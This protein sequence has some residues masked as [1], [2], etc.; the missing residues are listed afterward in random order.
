MVSKQHMRVAVTDAVDLIDLNSAN[1]LLVDGGPVSRLRVTAQQLVTL[2]DTVMEI[3]VSRRGSIRKPGP[4]EFN[5]S[6]RV[7]PRYPGQE[8]PAPETPQEREPQVFPWIA[9]AAPLLTG[10]VLFLFTQSP[11]SLIFIALSPVLVV[12]NYLS[13][14]IQQ[15]RTQKLAIKRFESKIADLDRELEEQSEVERATRLLEIPATGD[16]YENCLQLGPLLWTRRPEHWSFATVRLG[17]GT[18]P[19]RNR[20]NVNDHGRGLPEFT[21][22]VDALVASRKTLDRVPVIESLYDAGALGVAGPMEHTADT[23]RSILIQLAGLHSPGELVVC[24]ISSTQWAPELEW[25]KWL[26]HTSSPHSPFTGSHLADSAATAGSMLSALEGLVAERLGEDPTT[27]VRGPS[28]TDSSIAT[29]AMRLDRGTE[30]QGGTEFPA[31]VVV[32]TDDAP[33]DRARAVQ[34][35]ERAADANVFAI[36]VSATTETLPAACRTFVDVTGG[37]EVATVG[38]VRLGLTVT[39]VSVEGR[40]CRAGRR[41]RSPPCPRRR[42]RCPRRGLQRPAAHGVDGRAP[43]RMSS[44]SQPA[45]VVDR[46]RQNDSIHDRSGRHA[47]TAS[48]RR[49]AARARRA[50]G[51]RRDAP[52]PA[53]AGPARARRRHDRRGQERVPAGLGAR[54]GGRVQPRPRHVPL[55]RL[56]GRIGVRRLRRAPALRR[57]RHRPQPAPGAPRA[58]Q[59]ARR[60]AP[61]RAPAQPQEGEGPA[62]AREARRPGD[63][64]R[65][66]CSSSTSSPRSPARCPEFV[67]GVVDIAQR[68]RSLGIHL[69]MATQRPA[70]VIKDNLRANTNLRIALRMADESD[71]QDVVG[72][73]GRGDLR[74]VTPRPRHREDRP[75]P[76]HRLPVRLRGRLDAQRAAEPSVVEIAEPSLRCGD[77]VADA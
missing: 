34:L 62:R 24:A 66:S 37:R 74:P 11:L 47:A 32:I 75:G 36:W 1:G 57:P 53:H 77:A 73:H 63:A 13:T 12:G 8:Y 54:H 30:R 59:P 48:K 56:Q 49:H 50:G 27:E 44:P 25:L 15:R 58:H 60:A 52:R 4:I 38:F 51:R 20:V 71:S 67:D 19:S 17:T 2:G 43:R 42:R 22:R 6:P 7:E 5:R 41:V 29:Q 61:P 31:V 16:L 72:E 26:P 35:L 68:G 76:A 10:P 23:A 55:R 33:V 46:W 69:I 39:D 65:P 14:I 9:M 70:G 45:A 21:T 28:S 18:M 3:E 64:R 40:W